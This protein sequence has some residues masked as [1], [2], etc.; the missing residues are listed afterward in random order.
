MKIKFH[1]I[2][3]APEAVKAELQAVEKNFGTVLNL[4][5]GLAASP[6]ATKSYLALA[7][8]LKAHGVLNPIEQQVVYVSV[9]AANSCDY[10]VAAHSTAAG[11]AKMPD[12]VLA[13]LREQ[14]ALPDAKLEALRTFAL[15]M[16]D[17]RGFMTQDDLQAFSNAGYEQAHLLDVITI[18]AQK[19]MS[20]Y[21]N[22][23]ANTPLDDMFKP[24]EWQA[25]AK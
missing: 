1:T 9:S 25:T 6:A 16:R 24:M 3:S 7:G 14:R 19:T 23:I 13:A 18:M 22:H 17:Q 4:I 11:M 15:A 5:A 20:N 12:D 10:C 21:F 8:S 2:E